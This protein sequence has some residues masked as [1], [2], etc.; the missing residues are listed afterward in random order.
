MAVPCQEVVVLAGKTGSLAE[1]L[2]QKRGCLP[3]GGKQKSSRSKSK[4]WG[5][6]PCSCPG[7]SCCRCA[8]STLICGRNTVTVHELVLS[9]PALAAGLERCESI[10]D[11]RGDRRRF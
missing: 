4:R 10:Q 6:W 3:G 7:S 5:D 8:I 1:G 9:S 11:G 2:L